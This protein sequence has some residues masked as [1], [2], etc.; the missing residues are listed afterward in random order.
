MPGEFTSGGVTAI[1]ASVFVD[2]L[3]TASTIIRVFNRRQTGETLQRDDVC[4][5][6]GWVWDHLG[7]KDPVTDRDSYSPWA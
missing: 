5:I 4:I 3:A 1:V 2:V 7:R 6:V